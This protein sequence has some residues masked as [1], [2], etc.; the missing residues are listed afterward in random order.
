M[1]LCLQYWHLIF[2]EKKSICLNKRRHFNWLFVLLM[3]CHI[4]CSKLPKVNLPWLMLATGGSSS[5]QKQHA[6]LDSCL[7]IFAAEYNQLLLP[8]VLIFPPI[9][10]EA[11]LCAYLQIP[12][13][14]SP[15]PG[16]E[17][18]IFTVFNS[19]A[20]THTQTFLW[21]FKTPVRGRNSAALIVISD[22]H[23]RLVRACWVFALLCKLIY[24]SHY[25]LSLCTRIS[26]HLSSGMTT[27]K[28]VEGLF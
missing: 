8:T 26:A 12:H 15:R 7:L 27:R 20:D 22:L 2:I 6:R 19:A 16:E 5:L 23:P 11:N 17:A 4:F 13:S 24:F 14:A 21:R 1:P 3:F 18:S 25:L 10:L 28:I 9:C